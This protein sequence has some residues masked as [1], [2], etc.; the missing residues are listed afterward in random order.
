MLTNSVAGHPS[1]QPRSRAA[2]WL[3]ADARVADA[4]VMDGYV[5]E[6]APVSRRTVRLHH[7]RISFLESGAASGGPVLLLLHGLAGSAATWTPVLGLLGRYAHVIAPDLLGHG[8]SDKPRSGD[9][10]LGAYASGLRDLLLELDLD[11]ASVVG[12]SFGGGVGMQFA[13]QFPELTERLVLESSGGLGPEVH[14]A[15]RAATLPG[16]STV[17]KAVSTLI[18]SWFARLVHQMI[19]ATPGVPKVDLDDLAR[20]LTSLGEAGARGAFVQTVRGALDWSGQRLDGTN[21]LYLLT[22]VPVLLIG[23][24]NDSFIPAEHTIRAHQLLPASRLEIFDGAGHF[25]HAAQP[26]RFTAALLDFIDTTVP[27]RADRESLRRQLHAPETPSTNTPTP[28]RPGRAQLT[29]PADPP[30]RHQCCTGDRREL[31]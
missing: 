13:Y 29:Q 25:P 11:R 6:L 20:S 19:R 23:G 24:R 18:P 17:L 14:I 22:E 28:E 10:S 5:T 26:R 4:R 16:T 12:H 3:P 15:L 30:G 9:Y 27:A 31:A 8:Q 1:V 7:Q 21:R 2:H